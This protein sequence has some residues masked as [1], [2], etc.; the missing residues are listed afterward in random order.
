MT[1]ASDSGTLPLTPRQVRAARA[2]LTWSQQDLAKRAGI[3]VSTVADFERGQRTPVP[4]NAEAI[5]VALEK[6][7]I[8]FPP[9]GAVAG[10]PSPWLGPTTKS[11]A[12]ISW[13]NATDLS[14][15][16]ERRDGQGSLPALLSKL[17]RAG[18]G[19]VPHFPADEGVQFG[20]WDGTTRA[21]VGNDYVPAGVAGWEI[22]TQRQGIVGKA[23]ED[24]EKRTKDAGALNPAD[25]TF[26]F[27]TPRHWPEKD[28]WAAQKRS[29]A[30]WRGV[31]AYDGTDLVEWISL[32]PPVGQGLATALGRRPLGAR[33]LEEIWEEWSLA[34][35][36]AL[37][38]EVILSDR[39]KDVVA[40]LHWLR[41]EPSILALQSET[42]EEVAAFVYAAIAELPEDY[43]GHYLARS[44]VAETAA[45]ARALADSPTP[46][47]IVLLDPEPGLAQAIAR[48]GHHVLLVYGGNPG[49]VGEVRRLGRP[50]RQGIETALEAAGVKED[51][52]KRLARE[53]SRSLAV[54]RR[55]MASQT[56]RLPNWAQAAPPHALLA[57]LLAG[58]WDEKSE[59][60]RR[61]L[62]QLADT[63][64][65][66]FVADVTRFAGQFD[67][68]LHKVGSVWKVASPQD[69]WFLL[70]SYLSPA[71]VDRFERVAAD[72]F[73]TADPR[74]E[75]TGEERWYAPIHGVKPEYS[76]NLRRGLGEIL[77]MFALFGARAHTVEHADLRAG[78]VVYKLLHD[79]DSERWWSLAGDFQLL[80]EAAPDTFLEAVQHSL[81]QPTPPISAL[82]RSD[83]DPTFGREYLSNL[84]WALESLAWSPRLLGR[85]AL[86]LAQL[87]DM[88]P[89]GRYSNRPGKSLRDQ[90][91]LWLPQTGASLEERLKVLDVIRRRYPKAAWK[92]MLGILPS[93][94][95]TLTPA[96]KPRWRDLAP[97][98]V[99]DVTYAVVHKGAYEI[100][101]R[102]LDD[103]GRDVE[104]WAAV[105]KRLGNF[106]DRNRVIERLV[107]AVPEIRDAED[108]AALW[109]SVR[110]TLHHY[111]Q[112][113]D[114][115][116]AIPVSELAALAKVYEALTPSDPVARTAWLFGKGVGLPNPD[117]GWQREQEQLKTEKAKAATEVFSAAGIDGVVE[118]ANRVELPEQLGFSL[119]DASIDVAHRE[120]ILELALKSTSDHL[121]GLAYGLIVAT[122]QSEKEPWIEKLLASARSGNWGDRALRTVLSAITQNRW[123]WNL[124]QQ[125]GPDIERAY[126]RQVP[127]FA[128]VGE[129]REVQFAAEK[130]LEMGRAHDAVALL[131]SRVGEN[132]THN[133][134]KTTAGSKRESE[135]SSTLLIDALKQAGR[136]PLADKD[137]NGVTMF[138][139]YVVQILKH[140][141]VVGG[142]TEQTMLELEFMYLALLKFSERPVKAIMRALSHAPQLF[143]QLLCAMFKPT[144]E[145]GVVEEAPADLE[146]AKRLAS[147]AFDILQDW[148]VVPGTDA[149][150]KIDGA[151]LEEWVKEARRLAHE[152]GRDEIADQKIGEILSASPIGDDGI[153]PA[154]PVREI[155]ETARSAHLETGFVIGQQNRRGVTG[156]LPTDGGKQEQD[157]VR[158]FASLAKAT[159]LEWPR[160]SAVLEKLAK[161]YIENARWHDVHAEQFD[162]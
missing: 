88:D 121:Q 58:A 29:E 104:R 67:S 51:R 2:L 31:R 42:P 26:I 139:Y 69:A 16:A 76:E 97:E 89:G 105:L 74:Y 135:I 156:R 7:G 136:V 132:A 118:L 81:D 84:L 140:L 34:T 133:L 103:S 101:S 117:G 85:V 102:L 38:A 160:T 137:H 95:D 148:D 116:W 10:P 147:H 126:W 20:G 39:D 141:D 129:D 122:F 44:L 60:D 14:Q 94:H 12:P 30:V 127:V 18:G 92:L 115:D 110:R 159:A 119:I 77:I 128:I 62:A 70:A 63:P 87:D 142:I 1:V 152:T 57:A 9:G 100:A 124:A 27:V 28:E 154:L 40:V 153:W 108:R 149:S 78:G 75:M 3:A 32:Y 15:W 98:A 157:I 23:N 146:R 130:L 99:E 114:A 72:V 56:G 64:Y 91:V 143:I 52:A 150:G 138:Q 120:R 80:A 106:P 93:G 134:T 90:F 144:A 5:R 48:K 25:S 107:G 36:P 47:L 131:A 71:D 17:V 83:S 61:V 162:W 123:T 41:E 151:K 68:P 50:T 8:R 145:S 158:Q 73:A 125:C 161:S 53:S 65:E 43:A 96:A 45:M 24:Y 109:T 35:Q 46:L 33:Q 111:R 49:Q 112:F 55:L 6:A 54:L 113:P 4:N 11:G 155:I 86:I 66:T 13:V 79:A 21:D 19:A 22:G 59:S 37:T 82:F